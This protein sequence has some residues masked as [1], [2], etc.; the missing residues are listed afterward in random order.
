MD[1]ILKAKENG[2]CWLDAFAQPHWPYYLAVCLT[3]CLS[4]T[5]SPVPYGGFASSLPSSTTCSSHWE[6]PF[7]MWSWILFLGENGRLR[8]EPPPVFSFHFFNLHIICTSPEHPQKESGPPLVLQLW[9]KALPLRHAHSARMNGAGILHQLLP[10]PPI[11]LL[12]SPLLSSFCSCPKIWKHFVHFSA[13]ITPWNTSYRLN[14]PNLLC[15]V[16]PTIIINSQ[17]HQIHFSTS[18]LG[19]FKELGSR[20]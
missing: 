12:S 18:L 3:L 8:P 7:E 19:F 2:L 11:I 4:S 1:T 15:K 6:P 14:S 9:I 10:F 13:F 16:I 5:A 17:T 20:Q